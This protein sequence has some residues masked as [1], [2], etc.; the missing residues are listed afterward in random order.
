MFYVPK[1]LKSGLPKNLVKRVHLEGV[2]GI[3]SFLRAIIHL[4][5]F[6]LVRMR[7]VWV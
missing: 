4:P 6:S 7:F 2:D 3:D 5:P 1:L